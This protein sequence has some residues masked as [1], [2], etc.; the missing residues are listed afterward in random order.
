MVRQHLN[1]KETWST[2]NNIVCL[3]DNNTPSDLIRIDSCETEWEEI[4]SFFSKL[5]FGHSDLKIT[6]SPS[7]QYLKFDEF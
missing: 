6:M 2:K 4:I 7:R 1:N 3:F 5:N